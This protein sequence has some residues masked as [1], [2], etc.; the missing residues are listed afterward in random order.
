M[1]SCGNTEKTIEVLVQ[2]ADHGWTGA[3]QSYAQEKVAELNKEGKYK[4]NL[5]ACE[6]ATVEANKIDDL[7]AN[8]EGLHGIVMLPI[9]NTMEASVTKVAKANVP[10]VQ[11]D[12]VISTEAIDNAESRVAHVM[13]DNYGI[14]VATAKEFIAK[15]IKPGEKILIMPGDNSSVPGKRTA[16]FKDT[17]VK[18]GGWTKAQV[19]A[20]DSTD[21]TGWSRT[22]ARELGC[23]CSCKRSCRQQ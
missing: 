16:G 22:K 6:S 1:T 10:F 13:G 20:I 12:R 11:F 2:T 5:T 17:L 19:D 3:V 9:D 14:G 8:K 4:V 15:G 7:L 23:H 18:D 21:F